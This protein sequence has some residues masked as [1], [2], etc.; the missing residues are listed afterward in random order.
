M[1]VERHGRSGNA[2]RQGPQPE[3]VVWIKSRKVRMGAV[4]SQADRT[5]RLTKGWMDYRR[6]QWIAGLISIAF[7]PLAAAM[8]VAI[9]AVTRSDR[10]VVLFAMPL[11]VLV[12]GAWSWFVFFRCP[13][14]GQHFHI[15]ESWRLTVGRRC[16]HCG[17]ERYRVD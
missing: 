14:C 5:R 7:I 11:G 12:L 9:E 6:R 13:N 4:K 2:A 17:L 15:T 16:P 8:A 3:A 1:P 10:F